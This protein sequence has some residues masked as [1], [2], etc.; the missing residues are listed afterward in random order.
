VSQLRDFVGKLGGLQAEH[1]ALQL[2]KRKFYDDKPL[3]LMVEYHS[4]RHRIVGTNHSC[5]GIGNLQQV[6][7][8]TTKSA[9]SKDISVH[10][11]HLII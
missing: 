1:R 7:G 4:W 9:Q 6:A 11:T 8:N 3:G 5:E 10:F 2:R